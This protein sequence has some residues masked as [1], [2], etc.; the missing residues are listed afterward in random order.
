MASG[1]A[2][3]CC[4]CPCSCSS[5]FKTLAPLGYIHEASAVEA[6]TTQ[7]QIIPK[8]AVVPVLI[9]MYNVFRNVEA[10][11]ESMLRVKPRMLSKQLAPKFVHIWMA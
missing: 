7:I 3:A 6:D 5:P 11:V 2:A 4:P 10:L 1:Y 8:L 9:G